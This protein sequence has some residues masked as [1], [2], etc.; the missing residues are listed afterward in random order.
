MTG[1]DDLSNIPYEDIL[2]Y[3]SDI[4]GYIYNEF[5]NYNDDG[6]EREF[7]TE[8]AKQANHN[9]YLEAYGM[10]DNRATLYLSDLRK[11]L[12]HQD[13]EYFCFYAISCLSYALSKIRACIEL[14]DHKFPEKVLNHKKYDYIYDLYLKYVDTKIYRLAVDYYDA[15]HYSEFLKNVIEDDVKDFDEAKIRCRKLKQKLDEYKY[16]DYYI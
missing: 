1:E 9:K 7:P 6:S 13:E 8:V 16:K 2:N 5:R 10:L 15:L 12:H 3:Y 11:S 14:I 4:I